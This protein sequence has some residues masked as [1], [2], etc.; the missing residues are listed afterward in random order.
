MNHEKK[1]A[2]ESIV[3]MLNEVLDDIQS[4]ADADDVNS[5]AR[6]VLLLAQAFAEVKRS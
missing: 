3:L 1:V 4:T 6:A 5:F 2:L